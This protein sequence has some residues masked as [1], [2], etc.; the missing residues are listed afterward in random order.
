MNIIKFSAPKKI[1]TYLQGVYPVP[2][3]TNIP[4]WFKK[5]EHTQEKK[6]IKGCMPFLDSM[7]S[8]YLLKMPQD[9]YLKHNVW[10]DET[11]N[12]D[13]FFKYAMENGNAAELGL[14]NWNKEIHF[15]EQLE[16]SPQ[17]K[18]N[19]NLPI[20]KILNPF[21]IQTP[22]GYSCLFTAP[23]NNRDDR[24]EIMSG[25]VDTDVFEMEINFPFVINSDKYPSLETTIQRGTPYVQIIPF[26]REEWKM[27]LLF[28]DRVSKNWTVGHNIL[29]KLFNNYKNFYWKKKKWM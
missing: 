8:G 23:L 25:I 1:E 22:K 19:S 27:D 5:I 3:K 14:N 26:K 12:Y 28:E 10:N 9:L 7:T 4:E 18:K 21:H 11:N 6:T 24:F 17:I 29:R 15:K 2:I 20:Y 16:G 13:S